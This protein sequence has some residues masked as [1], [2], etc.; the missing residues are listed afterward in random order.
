M[1]PM[2]CCAGR[3]VAASRLARHGPAAPGQGISVR[4]C[5]GRHFRTFVNHSD[6][7][8]RVVCWCQQLRA[9][10]CQVSGP[11]IIELARCA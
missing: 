7:R 11:L 1:P 10:A 2:A 8:G 4:L 6:K 9:L 5:P 3:W